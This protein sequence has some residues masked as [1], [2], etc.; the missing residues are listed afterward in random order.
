MNARLVR[1]AGFV[2][3]P[4]LAAVSPLLVIPAVTAEFGAAGWTVMAL[5]LS[6]GGAAAVVAELGW[7]VTGPQRLGREPGRAGQ[8][9]AESL[10]SRLAAVAVLLPVAVLVTVLLSPAH[11]IAA[12]LLAA[13]VTLSALSPAWFLI[14]RGQ[15]WVLVAI[16]ALPRCLAAAVAAIAIVLGAPLV[17][18]GAALLLAAVVTWLLAGRLPD[19]VHLPGAAAFRAAPRVARE[20]STLMVARAVSTAYTTLPAAVLG[21]VAPGTVPAF[22]AVDRLA[23]M[24]LAVVAA[25]PSQMQRW[26]GHEDASVR[27]VR[28]PRALALNAALGVIAGTVVVLVMP[29]ATDLL[30]NGVVRTDGALVAAAATLVAVVCPS[31]GA[32]LVLVAVDRAPSITTAVLVSAPV[33]IAALAAGALAWGAAGGMAGLAVAEALGLAVQLIAL[34]VRRR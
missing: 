27:A 20:Q 29:T 33:G 15:S 1:L 10:A 31:R 21:V 17:A 12:G 24:G 13:A 23:R 11:Q 16:D 14:G 18:H 32:G 5:A 19:A 4:L 25:V 28:I 8:L 9:F 3:G 7:G 26:L 6:V 2:L 30:F 22:A 34:R